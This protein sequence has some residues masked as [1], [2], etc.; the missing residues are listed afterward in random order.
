MPTMKPALLYSPGNGD[1][2]AG[3]MRRLSAKIPVTPKFTQQFEIRFPM[4]PLKLKPPELF[5]AGLNELSESAL[6]V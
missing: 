1:C 2:G 3:F 6:V 4:P 5:N